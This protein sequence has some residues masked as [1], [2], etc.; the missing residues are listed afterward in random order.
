MSEDRTIRCAVVGLSPRSPFGRARPVVETGNTELVAVC[1]ILEDPA[2]EVGE[3]YDIPW[4]TEYEQMLGQD[5][6]EMVFIATPDAAHA[7][8]TVAALES[9]IHVLCEK[10]M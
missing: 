4:Y 2:R 5:D 7:P 1:D 10:P 3:E 9:G 6:I 8:Q